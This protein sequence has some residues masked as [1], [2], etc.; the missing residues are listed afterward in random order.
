M[1]SVRNPQAENP[2][3]T[4]SPETVT[5]LVCGSCRDASGSD[6]RPRPGERLAQHARER[7]DDA[8]IEIR[9]VECLGNCK[10]RL[11]AGL[12][13]PG[14]WTYVFGELTTDN[15]PDLIEAAK[16]FRTSQDGLLP[17]RGRPDCLKRGLIARIPPLDF[18]KEK[19]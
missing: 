12:A 8:D 9:E 3:E 1:P 6:V 14:A 15:A 7:L 17:W 4:E 18:Q 13:K 10:R 2:P 11:S 5:I 16:L 19:P